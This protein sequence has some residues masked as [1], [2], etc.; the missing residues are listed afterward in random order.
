[1][2]TIENRIGLLNSTVIV[3]LLLNK[4]E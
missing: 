3:E 2:M 1:M 4:S